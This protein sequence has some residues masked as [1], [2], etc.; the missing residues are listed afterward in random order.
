VESSGGHITVNFQT[1]NGRRVMTDHVYR[2]DMAYGVGA[3]NYI[4]IFILIYVVLLRRTGWETIA[5]S[6]D[7]PRLASVQLAL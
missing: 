2:T 3:S 6:C 7:S 4:Q 5:L 1:R